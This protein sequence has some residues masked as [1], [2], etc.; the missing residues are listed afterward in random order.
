MPDP[1]TR[2]AGS[3]SGGRSQTPDAHPRLESYDPASADHNSA[4][5]GVIVLKTGLHKANSR[6]GHV[7]PLLQLAVQCELVIMHLIP[8]QLSAQLQMRQL[9]AYEPPAATCVDQSG[10]VRVS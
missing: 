4:V 6:C 9:Q 7:P 8:T 10:H 1:C 5:H 3:R 2:G